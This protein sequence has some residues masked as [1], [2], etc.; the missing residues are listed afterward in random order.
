MS[1][2]LL[3]AEN[4]PL[5][6]VRHFLLDVWSNAGLEGMLVPIYETG[7]KTVKTT[8]IHDPYLLSDAD[9]MAP[10]MQTN[11]GKTVAA[12]ARRNPNARFAAV[13]RACEARALDELTKNDSPSLENWLIIGTDCLGCFPA[14]D[15]EWR[16]QKAG[17][18]EQMTRDLLRNARQG[19]IAFD[20]FRSACRMCDKPE[21]SQ[22]DLCIDLLGLP[23]RDA[24]LIF[25]RDETLPRKLGLDEITDGPAPS[26]LIV[27]HSLMLK[28]IE[29]RRQRARE[30]ELRQ[31][32]TDLPSNLDE[33]ADFLMACQPCRSCLEAC[34]VHAEELTSAMDGGVLS[35]ELLKHW[36][37]SCAECGMCEQACPRGVPLA[38][39]MNRIH[40]ELRSEPLA[41]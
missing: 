31:L 14:P 35:R 10:L 3:K 5:T 23:V 30:R 15:F 13:L 7:D 33:L 11:A 27:Q 20:R 1:T 4:D 12:L 37:V 39:I 26:E 38:A 9:P 24:I 17:S 36:L 21:P 29:E 41:V 16:V 34:P 2:W 40:R 19:G 22:V 8:L 25:A 28:K 32:A 18:V 6:T